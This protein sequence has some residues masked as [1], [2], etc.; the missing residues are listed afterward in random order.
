MS[1]YALRHEHLGSWPVVAMID[2]VT[3]TAV[4]VAR[5]GATVLEY[6]VPVHERL[7]NVVDGYATTGGMDTLAGSRFAVMCPFANRVADARYTFDGTSHDLAPDAS[8]KARRILHGFLRDA[9]FEL[10]SMDTDAVGASVRL[11]SGAIRPSAFAGYPFAVDLEVTFTLNPAGLELE[12][13]MHNVGDGPAPCFFGWHPYL[14]PGSDGIGE[15]EMKL[16]AQRAI[17]T[18]DALIPLPG[19]D[20]LAALDTTPGHDFRDWRRIGDTVLDNGFAHLQADD[21]GRIRSHLRDPESGLHMAVWQESGVI[22]VF[23]GDTL[24]ANA[25]RRAV[26]IEPMQ[27][28]TNAFNRADCADTVTLAAGASRT[29]RCGLDVHAP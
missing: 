8:G 12:A 6:L 25:A 18:D 17:V 7:R 16:P 4:R 11:R 2:T 23:T 21:D 27:T 13:V 24:D 10:V 5:R 20:A 9:D 3:G 19:P 15:L 28:M 1:R 14:R 22:Q 29:F 26:A